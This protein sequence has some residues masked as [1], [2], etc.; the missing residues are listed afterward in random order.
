[1]SDSVFALGVMA[2]LLLVIVARQVSAGVLEFMMVSRSGSTAVLL[3]IVAVLFY[4]NYTYT[5]LAVAVLSVFL[6][7]D[8]W[9]KYTSSDARR[10]YQETTRDKARF[11]PST[12]IDLQFA[13][14]TAKHDSPE[15][16]VKPKT[17][18]HLLI[19]PP[20][21]DTLASMCG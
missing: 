3:A 15:L 19:F 4:K 17:R 11:D 21:D 20:S 2:V 9:K 7:N 5:A 14:G 18:D 16:Y 8:L 10:L 12:S 6:L 1:M 13:N